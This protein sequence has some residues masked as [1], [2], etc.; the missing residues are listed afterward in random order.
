MSW[1]LPKTSQEVLHHM[2]F[3]AMS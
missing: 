2:Q 1:A 3:K